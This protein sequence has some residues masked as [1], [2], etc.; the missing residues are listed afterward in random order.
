MIN[1]LKTLIFIPLLTLCTLW[2][3]VFKGSAICDTSQRVAPHRVDTEMPVETAVNFIWK[4]LR[5]HCQM[6]LKKVP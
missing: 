5:L 1:Y 3:Y 6:I 4:L 2:V